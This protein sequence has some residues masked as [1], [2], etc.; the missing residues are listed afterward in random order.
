MSTQDG[1]TQIFA[2]AAEAAAAWWAEQLGSPVYRMVDDH[3]TGADR[4]RAD[5]ASL[6]MMAEASKTSV[7]SDQGEKFVAALAPVIEGKLAR[8]LSWVSLGVDYGPDPEL[9][10]AAKTAGISTSRFPWKTHMSVTKDYVTASLGYRAPSRLIWSSPEWVRP[11]CGTQR[12]DEE[13][14]DWMPRNELCGLLR[15]HDEEHGTWVPDPFRCETCGGTYTDH[16][17]RTVSDR[18]HSWHPVMPS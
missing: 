14:S 13:G 3:T 5:F 8:G 4:L 1:N 9:A 6:T 17:G 2:T 10:E 16:F 12:Y 11:P 18:D 15:F 7:S